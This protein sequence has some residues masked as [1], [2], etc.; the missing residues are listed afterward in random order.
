[1]SRPTAR[2]EWKR[3]EK[4][5]RVRERRG[6]P[7][8]R[9]SD[10]S[11]SRRPSRYEFSKVTMGFESGGERC[12]GWLYRPDRPSDPPVVVMAGGIA[13]ERSFGLPAYAERLAEAGYAVFLFDYRNHGDSEGEPRNLLSPSRQRTD[14]EAAI[15]G[16]RERDGLDTRR[17]VLWG[18]DL[19]GGHVLDV[20]AD[21]ARVKAVVAQTPVLSG[22]SLLTTNGYGYLAKGVLAGV[23]D[24]LQSLVAGPHTVSVTGDPGESAL[25]STPGAR[26]GYLD[27]VPHASE[28]NNETP[29]R[30]LL[31]LATY[32]AGDEAEAITC[33][34]LF[35][36]AE[37]DDVVSA[38]AV[39]KKAESVSDATFVRLP[40]GHFDLYEGAAFE[41]A[42][43]H[44][45]AFADGTLDRR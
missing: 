12:T 15:A 16:V 22:R 28:W 9:E 1:M 14:W 38:D 30:S 23:R 33:P 36:A 43:G 40:A 37:R 24:K 44:G 35:I 7:E 13:G 4:R 5:E 11:R 39:E 26:A 31:S 32:S 17:L 21:D 6:R 29:A 3:A 45:I 27:L 25:L 18:T 2:G 41:Q 42:V 34:V 10:R 20:A 19:G 8:R